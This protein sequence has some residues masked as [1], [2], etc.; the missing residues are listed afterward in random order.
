MKVGTGYDIHKLVKGRKL[1][2][3]GVEIPYEKGLLGHTDADVLVHAIIDALLGA[4]GLGDIGQTFPDGDPKWK[5]ADSLELLEIVNASL[6]NKGFEIGNIDTTLIMQ[7]PKIASYIPKMKKKIADILAIKEG[8]VSI[9][10]K[11]NEG[12]GPE[13][14]KE[15]ISAI[16][17]VLI[18]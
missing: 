15:A 4:S 3:A 9:K 11:T 7:E 17:T 1:I 5:D 14:N 16:A 8:Q 10:A 18:D 6:K 2:L 13:G 12:L